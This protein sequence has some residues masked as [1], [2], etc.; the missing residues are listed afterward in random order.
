MK[1]KEV[2]AL[3]VTCNGLSRRVLVI[4]R[5]RVREENNQ[6][7]R[8]YYPDALYVGAGTLIDLVNM[9]EKYGLS[10]HIEAHVRLMA[11]APEMARLLREFLDYRPLGDK[12]LDEIYKEAEAL[13]KR[14][15]GDDEDKDA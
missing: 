6:L 15:E 10:P 7:A 13:L 9:G 1:E 4:E 8:I 5:D 3:C 14:I 12:P 11:A 2:S